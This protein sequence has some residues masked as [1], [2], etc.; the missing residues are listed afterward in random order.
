MRNGGSDEGTSAP[1]PAAPVSVESQDDVALSAHV[2]ERLTKLRAPPAG[3]HTRR[4]A[5]ANSWIAPGD[6]EPNDS[7]VLFFALLLASAYRGRAE[8][9]QIW[10]HS[11]L[12]DA[13]CAEQLGP[14]CGHRLTRGARRTIRVSSG[15][16]LA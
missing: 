13:E 4:Y 9:L 12:D 11:V 7:E 15:C 16:R 2:R 10:A 3:E 6:S 8:R 5:D 1:F 14:L